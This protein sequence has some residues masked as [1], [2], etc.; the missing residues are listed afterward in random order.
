MKKSIYSLVLAD[1]VVAQIDRMAYAQGTSRSNL[2]NQ[3]LAEQLSLSTPEMRMKDIFG[4]MEQM[5]EETFQILS[6]PSDSMLQLRSPLRF[7]YNPTIR[8]QVELNREASEAVGVLR[9]SMRSTS[10]QLLDLLD[11][12]FDLW[13]QLEQAL[14]APK[15]GHPIRYRK[16]T[17]R[18]SREIYHPANLPAYSGED[19]GNA[20]TAYIR[21]ADSAMKQYFALAGSPRETQLA[22]VSRLLSEALR[23]PETII[24]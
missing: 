15:L 4:T 3:I 12:F 23:N 14:T 13:I 8:Y 20:I 19:V 22:A 7:K 11:G 17:G 1:D 21:L 10:R 6:Q 24:I 16:E 9:I 18:L 5:L 2:I